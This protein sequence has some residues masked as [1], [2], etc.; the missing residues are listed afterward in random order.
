MPYTQE[1]KNKVIAESSTISARKLADKYDVS[2]STISNWIKQ[3]NT[4][5]QEAV[6]PEIHAYNSGSSNIGYSNDFT[7]AFQLRLFDNDTVNTANAS[8]TSLDYSRWANLAYGARTLYMQNGI[9]ATIVDRLVASVVN[10]GLILQAITDNLEDSKIIEKNFKLWADNPYLCDYS[11]QRNWSELQ[12]QIYQLSLVYGDVLVVAHAS[13]QN[14]L[15]VIQVIS[16][17]KLT[18][19]LNANL[20]EGHYMQDGVQINKVGKQVAYWV[21]AANGTVKKIS[22]YGRVSGMKRTAWLV[23]GHRTRRVNGV[24][25]YPPL[26]VVYEFLKDV[27]KLSKANIKKG[28]LSSQIAAFVKKNMVESNSLPDFNPLAEAAGRTTDKKLTTTDS[29]NDVNFREHSILDSTVVTGLN[30]GEEI[31]QIKQESMGTDFISYQQAQIKICAY[32]LEVPPNVFGMEYDQ[33]FNATQATNN[34]FNAVIEAKRTALIN[35]HYNHV[36]SSFILGLAVNNSLSTSNNIVKAFTERNG[37]AFY[38]YC[39]CDWIGKV[40]QTSD[41]KKTTAAL[42]EQVKNGFSTREQATNKLNNGSFENNIVKLS[43]EKNK[44][45]ELGLVADEQEESQQ[46]IEVT[47]D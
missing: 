36:Y 14:N 32:A 34:Q 18:N 2:N 28:L 15:P 8:N 19:P 44:L 9:A 26:S 11:Q 12:A 17:D 25:G 38:G 7:A 1:F 45:E 29:D 31:V 21:T 10:T 13:K 3:A 4:P 43:E 37:L 30:A 5:T 46:N 42:V 6:Q 39:V 40:I 33:S 47:N 20:P 16:T 41:L 22:A 27:D 23:Y 24:R 35:Q